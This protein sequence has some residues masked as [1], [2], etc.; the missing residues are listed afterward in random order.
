MYFVIW[1]YTLA[2][3]GGKA[4]E[5]IGTGLHAGTPTDSAVNGFRYML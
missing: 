2:V 3:A 1:G 5:N 4:L